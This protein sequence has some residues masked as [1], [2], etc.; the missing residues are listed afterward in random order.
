MPKQPAQEQ[1]TVDKS[2]P[3]TP[4]HS[5]PEAHKHSAEP[6]PTPKPQASTEPEV[7][8]PPVVP[9]TPPPSGTN[10]EDPV[11]SKRE[12]PTPVPT[13]KGMFTSKLK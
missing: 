7:P 1:N 9:P 2:T 8:S 6:T 4:A 13:A 10:V 12:A 3:L 11:A 5:V